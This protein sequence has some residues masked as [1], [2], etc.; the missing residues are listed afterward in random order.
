MI[1][2]NLRERVGSGQRDDGTKGLANVR[3]KNRGKG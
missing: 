1:Y 3:A 2:T